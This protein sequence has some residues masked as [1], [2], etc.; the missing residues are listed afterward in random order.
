M[1]QTWRKDF[2]RERYL[3]LIINLIYWIISNVVSEQL[4]S[5]DIKRKMGKMFRLVRVILNCITIVNKCLINVYVMYQSLPIICPMCCL[6]KHSLTIMISFCIFISSGFCWKNT[7]F[8]PFY[9]LAHWSCVQVYADTTIYCF[10]LCLK[11]FIFHCRYSCSCF[12]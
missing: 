3:R 11:L 1:H 5:C 7:I 2:L 4:W 10:F 12:I 8:N 6:Y 9:T